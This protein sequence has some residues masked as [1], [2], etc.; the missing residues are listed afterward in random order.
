MPGFKNVVGPK[1][2]GAGTGSSTHYLYYSKKVGDIMSVP[3][4][5]QK[6]LTKFAHQQ[7][8]DKMKFNAMVIEP[9]IQTWEDRNVTNRGTK[10]SP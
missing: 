8:V 5:A 9:L 10:L 3:N 2:L 4:E 1:F 6:A 7:A